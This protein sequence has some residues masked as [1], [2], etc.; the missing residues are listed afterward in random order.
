[1]AEDKSIALEEEAQAIIR[2]L[3][4]TDWILQACAR[5]MKVENRFT[6]AHIKSEYLSFP[7]DGPPVEIGLRAQST[8]LRNSVW[9]SE[10]VIEDQRVESGIGSNVEYAEIHETGGKTKPH[11]ITAKGGG[12]LQFHIGERVI[13]RKSVNHPGSDMPARMPFQR[14]IND[15]LNDYAEAISGAVVEAWEARK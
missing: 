9:A 8:R 6:V 13:Y 7:K 11:V 1:M 12:M 15:R 4:A 5:A 3:G 14:G 2:D 10:P